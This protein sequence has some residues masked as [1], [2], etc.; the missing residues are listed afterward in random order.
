MLELVINWLQ[1]DWDN[2]QIHT[3]ALLQKV[4]LG[5]I[6]TADIKDLVSPDILRVEGCSDL[7]DHVIKEQVSEKSVLSLSVEDP[8]MFATRSVLTVRGKTK[9]KN[10][11]TQL[12]CC[13]LYV[14]KAIIQLSVF[15]FSHP[16][17]YQ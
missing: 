13:M 6:A 3:H 14:F 16:I 15:S 5:L 7:I 10:P 4:R 9:T 17:S 1:H 8:S 12:S 11:E 2:R